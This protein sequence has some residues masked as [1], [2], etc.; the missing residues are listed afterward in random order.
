MKLTRLFI[1]CVA[2]LPLVLTM[3]ACSLNVDTKP[4]AGT[5]VVER[6]RVVQPQVIHEHDHGATIT[7]HD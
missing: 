6:E 4:G 3:G 5:H 7:V 1:S 2:A